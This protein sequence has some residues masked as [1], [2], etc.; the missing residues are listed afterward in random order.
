VKTITAAL[1]KGGGRML[2][3]KIDILMETVWK[4]EKLPE[5]WNSA[6]I[7]P[8]YRKG[9]KMKH[10]NYQGILLLKVTYKIFTQLVA[11][12]LEPY[13]QEV[14]GDYQCGFHSG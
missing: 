12:Y 7:C 6:I 11:K 2:W 13:V 9:N 10:N 14:L 3:R 1:V 8:T 4:E 5:E